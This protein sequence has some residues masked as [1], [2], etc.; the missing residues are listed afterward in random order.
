MLCAG[1]I[2]PKDKKIDRYIKCLTL[3]IREMVTSHRPE[4][5]D[6]T[7]RVDIILT[8]QLVRHEKMV[9]KVEAK[10]NED[11]KRKYNGNSMRTSSQNSQKK[12]NNKKIHDTPSTQTKQYIG[13]QPLCYRH[14]RHHKGD[15]F[16]YSKCNKKGQ[17]Y[18]FCRNSTPIKQTR[19][20]VLEQALE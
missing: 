17:T 3:P 18:N 1:F 16:F 5:Y 11:N 19:V 13:K 4:T 14:N 20:R 15:C 2:T 6:H 12:Q 7:K 9:K 10:R 8:N